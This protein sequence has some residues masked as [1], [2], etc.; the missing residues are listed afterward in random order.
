MT[1]NKVTGKKILE[2]LTTLAKDIGVF[3]VDI[4]KRAYAAIKTA[5]SDKKDKKPDEIAVKTA[6]KTVKSDDGIKPTAD[7]AVKPAAAVG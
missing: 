2:D 5:L 3:V 1:E 7:A 6:D 4:S